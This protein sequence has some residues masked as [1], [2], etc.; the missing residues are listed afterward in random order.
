MANKDKNKTKKNK[1]SSKA[2]H[3][4]AED[5]QPLPTA[6]PVEA[7]SSALQVEG[8]PAKEISSPELI[9]THW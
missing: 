9:N 7:I 6:E 5:F 2:K 4:Q 3:T 1:K 8:E